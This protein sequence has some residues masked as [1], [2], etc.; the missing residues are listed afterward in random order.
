VE[1]DI[2]HNRFYVELDSV[3]DVEDTL[4]YFESLASQFSFPIYATLQQID[5]ADEVKGFRVGLAHATERAISMIPTCW[6]TA[7]EG[8][9]VP[10]GFMNNDE[11]TV[12]RN[13]DWMVKDI[14]PGLIG[15]YI[16]PG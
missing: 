6:T 2:K 15:D 5:L 12:N 3:E 13:V 16:Q 14:N 9:L 11:I 1:H 10:P 7:V 4:G 8:K